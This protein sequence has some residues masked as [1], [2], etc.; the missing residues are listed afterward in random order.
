ML[1]VWVIVAAL[2]IVGVAAL[3]IGSILADEVDLD[4]KVDRHS[5][6]AVWTLGFLAATIWPLIIPLGILYGFYCVFCTLKE[7]P[8]KDI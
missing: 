6:F 8:W 5:F 7:K 1:L 4:D 3:G 2:L